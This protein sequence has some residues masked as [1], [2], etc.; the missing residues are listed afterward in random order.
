MTKPLDE[1]PSLDAVQQMSQALALLN[2]QMDQSLALLTLVIRNSHR[3]S[4]INVRGGRARARNAA[5]DAR[6]KFL[7][8]IS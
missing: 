5:R 4:A 1:Q 8:R 7:S 6:G 2:Q 3:K